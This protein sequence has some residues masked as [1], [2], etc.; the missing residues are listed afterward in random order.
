MANSV[1]KELGEFLEDIREREVAEYVPDVAAATVTTSGATTVVSG[2]AGTQI[3][4]LKMWIAYSNT[5]GSTI[6]ISAR[7]ATNTARAIVVPA[8]A[9]HSDGHFYDFIG[10]PLVYDD[11]EDFEISLSADIANCDILVLYAQT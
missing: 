1:T 2:S 5:S 3:R 4:I 7:G 11:G 8:P 10:A 9:T 6:T